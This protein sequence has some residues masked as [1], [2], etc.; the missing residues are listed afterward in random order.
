MDLWQDGDDGGA[1]RLL[2]HP[3]EE[4]AQKIRQ[5]IGFTV[6]RKLEGE[7]KEKLLERFKI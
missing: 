7:E 3:S 6:S 5:N 1:L 4:E 2:R